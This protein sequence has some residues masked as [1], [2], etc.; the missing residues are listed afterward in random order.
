MSLPTCP[1][2]LR[3]VLRTVAS[4]FAA[5][6]RRAKWPFLWRV[7]LEGIGVSLTAVLV[8]GGIFDLGDRK[9]LDQWPVAELVFWGCLVAPVIETFLC[10]MLPVMIARTLRLG[11][12]MQI[13][14]SVVF[15]AAAHAPS[16]AI[17]VIGAGLT[18]GFYL[19]FTYVR[20]REESLWSA[21]Y[22]TVGAHLVHNALLVPILL[23]GRIFAP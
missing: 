16:G 6:Q 22:M 7:T 11:F 18:G 9:D 12:W 3:T 20:W 13:A 10:Q 19:A 21:V 1:R 4:H 17:T 5:H 8:I 14:V 23:L 2:L 15:F